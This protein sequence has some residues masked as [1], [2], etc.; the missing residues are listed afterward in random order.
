Q[1]KAAEPPNNELACVTDRSRLGPVWDFIVRN[2]RRTLERIG[3]NAQPTAEH[4]RHRWNARQMSFQPG[5]RFIERSHNSIPA[6]HAD[7]KFPRV[8]AAPAFKPSRARS[9]LR[10][11]A[12]APMPPIWIAIEL[13]FAKPQR[14][15]VAI[16]ND[17]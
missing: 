2:R 14:A 11:G 17:L 9:D 15:K 3:E 1:R 8:P 7:M 13:R 4:N 6:M 12:S 5:C 10:F 16:T